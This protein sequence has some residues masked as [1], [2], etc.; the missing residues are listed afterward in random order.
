MESEQ[1]FSQIEIFKGR[2]TIFSCWCLECFGFAGKELPADTLLQFDDDFRFAIREGAK[3]ININAWA[4]FSDSG[5][6]LLGY[7]NV[8]LSHVASECSLS[9]LGH[10]SR[11]Y[12]F[13]PPGKPIIILLIKLVWWYFLGI[14]S[15]ATAHPLRAHSG[16]EHVFCFGDILLTFAWT[17]IEGLETKRKT[18]AAIDSKTDLP[19]TKNKH[20]FIRT[21]FHGTTHCDFCSKKVSFNVNNVCV[22]LDSTLLDLVER[23]SAVQTMRNVLS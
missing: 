20:D 2:Q 23:C 10:H 15:T 4:T 16:F 22:H 19:G 5:D 8:P 17:P 3:Y 18:S 14:T 6:V 1:I 9:V 11:R 12:S 13:L 7:L 21:Q